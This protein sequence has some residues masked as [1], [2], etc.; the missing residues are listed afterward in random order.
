MGTGRSNKKGRKEWI[1]A[2]KSTLLISWFIINCR[3]DAV[4]P[5]PSRAIRCGAQAGVQA[6]GRHEFTVLNSKIPSKFAVF[7]LFKFALY[8]CKHFCMG[9]LVFLSEQVYTAAL[10]A[11]GTFPVPSSSLPAKGERERE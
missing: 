5:T 8:L 2:T 4:L 1:S 11:S 10:F 3:N 6:V 7:L 9:K